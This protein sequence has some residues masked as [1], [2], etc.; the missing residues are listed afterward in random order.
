MRSAKQKLQGPDGE[1]SQSSKWS[2]LPRD[3]SESIL[4]LLSLRDYLQFGLVCT[5]WRTMVANALASKH[6]LP[7]PQLPELVIPNGA[8]DSDTTNLCFIDLS[9]EK[10]INPKRQIFRRSQYCCGCF[11]GWL[12]MV[13]NADLFSSGEEKFSIS[14]VLSSG[15]ELSAITNVNSSEL[16]DESYG[17][18]INPF[19]GNLMGKPNHSSSFFL[20]NPMSGDR[21]VLPSPLTITPYIKPNESDFKKIV[22]SSSPN[23]QDCIIV[24]LLGT[25]C[26]LAVCKLVNKCWTLI[27]AEETMVFLDIEIIGKTLYVLVDDGGGES[28]IFYDLEDANAPKLNKVASLEHKPES[29]AAIHAHV[30]GRSEYVGESDI[31]FLTKDN[32][33]GELLMIRLVATY[34]YNSDNTTLVRHVMFIEKYLFGPQA[35]EFRVWKMDKCNHQWLELHDLD[36]RLLYFKGNGSIVIS[37]TSLNNPQ[38][39]VKGNCIYFACFSRDE[40]GSSQIKI[41]RFCMTDKSMKHFPLCDLSAANILPVMRESFWFIPNIP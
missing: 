14:S 34:S 38:E 25:Y 24:G 23:S 3:I 6:C 15:H 11:E 27:E 17:A 31:N 33:S 18:L 9:K 10:S 35:K 8:P 1:G 2:H 39:F 22:A 12:F 4:K 5:S 41:G 26:H 20:L 7:A 32:I 29:Y 16:L 30:A 13:D 36:G 21:I 28:T 40:E 19:N 37:S